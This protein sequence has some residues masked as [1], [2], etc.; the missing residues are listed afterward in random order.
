MS[1][2][3]TVLVRV[4]DDSADSSVFVQ[5]KITYDVDDWRDDL[6]NSSNLQ[7][8]LDAAPPVDEWTSVS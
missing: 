8:V 4:Y 5:R 6:T 2:R 3:A 1:L 7:E